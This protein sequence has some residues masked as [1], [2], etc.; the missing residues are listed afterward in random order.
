[1]PPSLSV[2]SSSSTTFE[3]GHNVRRVPVLGLGQVRMQ[4]EQSEHGGHNEEWNEGQRTDQLE[5][6]NF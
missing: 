6:Y 5:I 4:V 2:T 3:G 1:L